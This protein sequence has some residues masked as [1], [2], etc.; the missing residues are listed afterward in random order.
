MQLFDVGYTWGFNAVVDARS[1]SL[2][3]SVVLSIEFSSSLRVDDAIDEVPGLLFADETEAVE[4]NNSL[5]DSLS[6]SVG[7]IVHCDERV[8]EH[9]SLSEGLSNTLDRIRFLIHPNIKE[10]LFLLHDL[11]S[12]IVL[13]SFDFSNFSVVNEVGESLLIAHAGHLRNLI[14]RAHGHF[15]SSVQVVLHIGHDI[16]HYFLHEH[17]IVSFSSHSR[18]RSKHTVRNF[19]SRQETTSSTSLTADS[20]CMLH[21]PGYQTLA[22]AESSDTFVLFA[23]GISEVV[24]SGVISHV[25]DHGSSE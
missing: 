16:L 6:I 2:N 19:S 13:H 15:S 20:R 3:G 14:F 18:V 8:L 4:E 7:A 1:Q 22:G 9:I 12:Y 5:K 11:L 24:L 10:L 17:S 25:E 23:L 21:V